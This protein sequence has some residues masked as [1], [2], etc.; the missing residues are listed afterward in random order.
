MLRI[1]W[2]AAQWAASQEGLSSM[3]EWGKL[4]G[5]GFE[6]QFNLFF[7]NCPNPSS[8]TMALGSTQ[9]LSEMSTK[10]CS[11]GVKSGRRVRLITLPPSVIRLSRKCGSLDVS[12]PYGPSR[13]VTGMALHFS[14]CKRWKLW[15]N[16]K[17]ISNCQYTRYNVVKVYCKTN[18]PAAMKWN[19]SCTKILKVILLMDNRIHMPPG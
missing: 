18:Y 4:E 1:S 13:P 9:P 19:P 6:S 17:F 16:S 11:E 10:Y 15:S 2:V 8:R 3:S 14:Y 7:F 5:R 12:Q